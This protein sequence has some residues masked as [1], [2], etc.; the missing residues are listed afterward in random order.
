MELRDSLARFLAMGV[1]A[2]CSCTS[3]SVDS[4][5]E[6]TGVAQHWSIE[7]VRQPKINIFRNAL[8]L[9]LSNDSIIV[10]D[11][12]EGKRSYAINRH[13]SR[14][15]ISVSDAVVTYYEVPVKLLDNDTL[16]SLVVLK[17]SEGIYKSLYAPAPK[18]E[19]VPM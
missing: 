1:L 11:T 7:I 12:L 17:N 4:K 15:L 9:V 6:Q 19:E 13:G 5:L 3:S 2:M 18:I 8:F 16:R 10:N 14:L